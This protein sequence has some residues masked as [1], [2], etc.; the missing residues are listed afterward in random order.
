M[1]KKNSA[2]TP[3]TRLEQEV[4]DAVMAIANSA[5][6]NEITDRPERRGS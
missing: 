5:L 2:E 1:T 3:K 6:D 4:L